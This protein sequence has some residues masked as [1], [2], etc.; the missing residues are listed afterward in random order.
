MRNDL[1]TN[2]SIPASKN[3]TINNP[4][5]IEKIRRLAFCPAD[6]SLGLESRLEDDH[7]LR[8]IAAGR[9]TRQKGFDLLIEAVVLSGLKQLRVTVL[10]EGPLR[11]TLEALA[12]AQ[13]VED[14][15]R[16]IGFQKNPYA[17]MARA[18][19]FVLSSRYEGFPNAM[20][21]ALA[22]GT[23]VIA[24]PAPGGLGEIAQPVQGVQLA[25]AVSAEALATE[26]Q[27]F[28]RNEPAAAQIDLERF[29]AG[30]IARKYERVLADG[31]AQPG[32]CPRGI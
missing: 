2:L 4:L 27:K 24:T 20:L 29:H 23:P 22:C 25:A 31:N 16:F 26:L 9:L 3:T 14:Q 15:V 11:G 6:S 12:K 8:L 18:D 5:G 17:L 28:A 7:S 19:A 13:G 30:K 21:E 1:V 32:A 10:G